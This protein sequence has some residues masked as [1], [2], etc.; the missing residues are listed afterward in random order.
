V[1]LYWSLSPTTNRVSF[2]SGSKYDVEHSAR[3]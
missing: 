3:E 1:P 2:V